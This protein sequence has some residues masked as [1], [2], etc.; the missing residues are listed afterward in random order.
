MIS[1]IFQQ[2]IKA[3]LKDCNVASLVGILIKCEFG[4]TLRTKKYLEK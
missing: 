4:A 1:A 2:V 3:M